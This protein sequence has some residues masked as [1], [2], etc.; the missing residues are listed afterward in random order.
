MTIPSIGKDE[1]ELKLSN[2]DNRENHMVESLWKQSH[3][4]KV[5]P[6]DDPPIPLLCIYLKE[7]VHMSI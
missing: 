2:I 4:L 6:T 5:K 3:F 1:E 7:G